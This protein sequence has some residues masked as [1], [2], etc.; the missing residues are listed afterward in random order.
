MISSESFFT[1]RFPPL[2]CSLVE[3]TGAPPS[4]RVRRL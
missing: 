1:S 4:W 3:D 2:T